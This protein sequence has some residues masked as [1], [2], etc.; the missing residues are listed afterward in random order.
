MWIGK[1]K[2]PEELINAQVDGRLVIF[3]GLGYL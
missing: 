1:I 2:L 3:A